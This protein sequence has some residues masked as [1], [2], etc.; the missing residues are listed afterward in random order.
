CSCRA[1]A[2]CSLRSDE[3]FDRC[4][5]VSDGDRPLFVDV[6]LL[7]FAELLELLVRKPIQDP[8]YLAALQLDDIRLARLVVAPLVEANLKSVESCGAAL[9]DLTDAVFKP[10]RA[11]VRS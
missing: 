9:H 8:P 4:Q 11:H 1:Q 2:L 10:L 6:A 5:L 7:N 3:R